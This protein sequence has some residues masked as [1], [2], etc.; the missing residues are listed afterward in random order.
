MLRSVGSDGP[1]QHALNQIPNRTAKKITITLGTAIDERL[2]QEIWYSLTIV[3][4]NILCT[5]ME[6]LCS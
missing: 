6:M 5:G 2:R 4:T 3:V 1:L